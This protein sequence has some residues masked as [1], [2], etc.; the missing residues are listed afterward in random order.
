MNQEDEFIR[1]KVESKCNLMTF[2]RRRNESDI[3]F[4]LVPSSEPKINEVLSEIDK[5]ENIQ[6]YR[7]FFNFDDF[8]VRKLYFYTNS[9]LFEDFKQLI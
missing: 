4:E 9:L 7:L 3:S 6:K 8:R 2:K 1:P 5:Y